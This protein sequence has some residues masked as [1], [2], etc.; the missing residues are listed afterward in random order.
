M[1]GDDPDM[2]SS[3]GSAL[4]GVEENNRKRGS[5]KLAISG[6]SRL[7]SSLHSH[8]P[9]SFVSSSLPPCLSCSVKS[10]G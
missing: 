9:L 1:C 6:C 8:V 2:L 3:N 10:I 7:L 4:H 5:R